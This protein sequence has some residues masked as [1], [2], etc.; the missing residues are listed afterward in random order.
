MAAATNVQG[1]EVTRLSG[2]LGAEVRGV[3]LEKAGPDDADRIR[4]LL[5]D[6]QVLFFPDQHLTPDTHI[7]FG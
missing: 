7:A 3:S 6:Y 2:S 5:M 4:S 1:L